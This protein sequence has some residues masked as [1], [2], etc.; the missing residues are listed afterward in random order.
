MVVYFGRWWHTRGRGHCRGK[1]GKEQ[2]HAQAYY[3]G[4]YYR[5]R[6]ISTNFGEDGEQLDRR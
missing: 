6:R 2:Q 4:T 3:R 5:V 1:S